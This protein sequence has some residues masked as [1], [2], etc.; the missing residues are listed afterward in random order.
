MYEKIKMLCKEKGIAITKLEAELGFARGSL[1][2]IDNHKPSA[3]KV[4]K[5]ARFFGISSTFLTSTLTTAEVRE[6][7]VNYFYN[8]NEVLNHFG[9]WEEKIKNKILL[10]V[11]GFSRAG[12]PNL[13]I[14]EIDEWEEI[15]PKLAKTGNFFALHIIGDSMQPLLSEN[16]VVIVKQQNDADTGDIVIAKINGDDACC[17]KLVKHENGITLISLNQDYLPMYFSND[18]IYEKPVSIIGK[19]IEARRKF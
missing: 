10:P 7:G 18:D 9:N 13:A 3:E 16:D 11:L 4:E 17:K 1:S 15:S 6:S 19:V 14:E 2:K 8:Q 12:I 5:I